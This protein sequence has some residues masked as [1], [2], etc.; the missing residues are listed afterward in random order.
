MKIFEKR[1]NGP[2]RNAVIIINK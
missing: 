1:F 2:D